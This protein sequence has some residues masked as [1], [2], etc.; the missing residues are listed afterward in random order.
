[1]ADI[2]KQVII[3]AAVF[4]ATRILC[5]LLVAP[6]WSDIP[7]YSQFSQNILD[8]Q[9]PYEDFAIEYPPIALIIFIIPGLLAKVLGN[10]L[11]SYRL[12]MLLFDLGNLWLLNRLVNCLTGKNERIALK[13]LLLYLILTGLSFQ[14][15]YDRFDIAVAFMLLLAIYLAIV[16]NQWLAAYITM[17]IAVLLKVFPIILIPLFWLIHSKILNSK[18][19]STV[20]LSIATAIFI[21]LS[22][23]AGICFGPWWESIIAYHGGRG[24]QIESIYGSIASIAAIMGVP[25][26]INHGFGS[27]NIENSFTPFLVSLSPFVTFAAI[28]F[29]YYLA[30][31]TLAFARGKIQIYKASIS[32]ILA[33][34]SMFIIA[35]K[36]LS[37]QYF[38][39]LFPFVALLNNRIKYSDAL[40]ICWSFVAIATAILF[41]YYYPEM[42][43]QKFSGIIPLVLRNI[44]LVVIF[45]LLSFSILKDNTSLQ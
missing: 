41:P 42:V 1:M 13:P 34:L 18:R 7:I 20:E 4:I 19:K 36:V 43:M 8:G 11:T 37:P 16:K 24:I 31:Q 15:L 33:V 21:I 9:T 38:L 6:N 5:F 17:W 39:W 12:V 10:Y 22:W 3:L 44:S 45:A 32:G 14:L 25:Y 29:G 2:R 30:Y 27:Y 35:N 40:A 26:T 28:L 23:G